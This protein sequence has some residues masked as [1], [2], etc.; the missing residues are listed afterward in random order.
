MIKDLV[1]AVLPSAYRDKIFRMLHKPQYESDF[2]GLSNKEVFRKIYLENYWRGSLTEDRQFSSGTG[3]QDGQIVEGYVNAVRSF[4]AEFDEP[5]KIID[6]GCGDFNVGS[7]IAPLSSSYIACD[8]VDEVIEENRA[9]FD[10][11]NV[12]FRVI[13]IVNDPLPDGDVA[14]VRQVL[15]HLSNADIRKFT[16]KIK[17]HCRYLVLTEHLPLGDSFVPNADKPN[18]PGIRLAFN[19]GVVL[20]EEPFCI[21]AR[22]ERVLCEFSQQG[23]IIRTTLFAF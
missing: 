9:N 5:K 10:L 20:S 22:T 21:G 14:L 4:L 16:A 17:A 3:S 19:S 11:P 2:K 23:G 15:Q 18:G 1:K 8:L 13:D 6:L 12:E 7:K